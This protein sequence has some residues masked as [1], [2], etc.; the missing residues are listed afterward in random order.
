MA[1]AN[2]QLHYA[3]GG[4]RSR[5]T[6]L[7]DLPFRIGSGPDCELRLDAP[8]VSPLHAVIEADGAGYRLVNR[9]VNGT[10]REGRSI[11]GARALT[12]GQRIEIGEDVALEIRVTEPRPERKARRRTAASATARRTWLWIGL[13][14][15]A[16]ALAAGGIGLSALAGERRGG[17]ATPA[18]AREAARETET[19]LVEQGHEADHAGALAQRLDEMLFRAWRLESEGRVPGAAATYQEVIRLV[20]SLRAPTTQLAARQLR[21]SEEDER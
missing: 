10:R 18:L 12:P 17:H 8:L 3:R 6:E 14:T 1:K 7:R 4:R 16:F 11:R 5:R 19:Y 20:P 21:R 2:P 15:Y 13:G 9:S